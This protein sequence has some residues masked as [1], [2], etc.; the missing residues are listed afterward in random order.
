MDT[1][2]AF[3]FPEGGK[4]GRHRAPRR[5]RRVRAYLTGPLLDRAL[6]MPARYDA[7]APQDR[8]GPP[9]TPFGRW[10]DGHAVLL[11]ALAIAALAMQVAY[12]G[13]RIAGSWRGVNP[14]LWAALLSTELYGALSLLALTFFAWHPRRSHR[15]AL[16]ADPVSVDVFICTYNE[17]VAVLRPTLIGAAALAYP[18]TTYLLD[19][20]RR[21]EMAALAR[22]YGAV[23]L[24]RPDNAHAKAG[25]LNHALRV[26]HG[27]LIFVLDADHVPLPD[28]LTALVGY[29]TD[30][31]LALVQTP[32]D[33]FNHDSAQHYGV[34][35]HEQ[36]VFF[37]VVCPGKDRHGAA[38][39]C[40]SATLI[41]RR[42]LLEVG[43]VATE[44]IAEDFHTTIKMQ[45]LGWT[46]RYHD[47]VLVQGLGPHDLD[48]YLLQRDRWARGNLSVLHT[49]ESPLVAHE[50]SIA[51]RWSFGAS[52]FAYAAGPMRAVLL[53]VLGVSLWSGQLPLRAP[54]QVLVLLWLPS[55]VLAL[56]AGSAQCRGYMRASESV[57][58]ELLTAEINLRAMRCLLA[59][60]RTGFK[61]T[62]KDGVDTGGWPAVRRLRLIGILGLVLAAGLV[63]RALGALG[64]PGADLL[65]PLQS[66]AGALIPLMAV[67]EL[68]RVA[69][70]LTVV[71]RRRQLRNQF[72]FGC[73]E[74]AGLVGT[75]AAIAGLT[76]TD[77]SLSGLGLQ[78]DV[79]VAT[80]ESAI[81]WLA[82][83][84]LTGGSHLVS[85][86]VHV[87]TCRRQADG[88][89]HIGV[90]VDG[91]AAAAPDALV[92][93]CFI[94]CPAR[95]LRGTGTIPA[96]GLDEVVG[97][98]AGGRHQHA[99]SA[100]LD[101]APAARGVLARVPELA[102]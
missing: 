72:R 88:T 89:F 70:T 52:L 38:F 94:V 67:I 22:R 65:P 4:A 48:G 17:S 21:P 11:R 29:F 76:L 73:A 58:F 57:H 75:S 85:V 59:P 45:R 16:P 39:W 2:G 47:E 30:P 12:L 3:A 40:G 74:P 14:V 32:H 68:R 41:R 13:W 66:W 87:R 28:A 33:F 42:A 81:V 9:R 82:L 86:S 37:E 5:A 20:G 62:P 23:W 93:F 61:V 53:L 27:D 55:T 50:L 64:V 99:P 60:S 25:N 77:A 7:S 46:T 79:P 43:G 63:A 18:H 84:D 44:T 92:K 35:R 101:L 83:P 24:T 80:G 96:V 90:V 34:G 15:P 26:T 8:P 102:G 78:S 95:R 31:A 36:S 19:D 49:P 71:G 91:G 100:A 10:F 51:Q 98:P 56:A 97:L 6:A 54:W 69:R 1:D